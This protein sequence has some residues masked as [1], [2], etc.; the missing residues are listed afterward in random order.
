MIFRGKFDR[1]KKTEKLEYRFEVTKDINRISLNLNRGP[2]EHIIISLE[3]SEGRTRILT[4]FKTNKKKYYLTNHWESTSNCC[5]PGELP[6]GEW[7]LKV[8]KNYSVDDEFELEIK[9]ENGNLIRK[10]NM[11][12]IGLKDNYFDTK[13]WY[14][15]ELHNHTNISDGA[16]T[17]RDLKKEL[18]KREI[19]FICP[20]EHNSVLTK[21]P[22]IDIPI[23]PSTELTLDDLGHFNLFGLKRLIDY[24]DL[25]DEKEERESS[26]KKI[27][28]EVKNQG[29]YI[30][31]NHPFH[32]TPRMFLGLFY[33]IDL[34]DLDFIEVINSPTRENNNPYYDRK[35]LEALDMLWSDGHKIFAVGGSDNHGEVLGD[36]L[37]YI[38]LDK[39]ETKNILENMKK[40]R[41]YIS[42][43]GEI[44]LRMENSGN[45]VYPGDE[46]KGNIS[47]KII[48]SQ[49]L[50]WKVIKNSKVINM[51][52]GQEIDIFN[53]L[54]DGEYL[55]IEGISVK[56]E[57]MVVINPIY[58][59]LKKPVLEKWFEI[60]DRVWKE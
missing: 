12:K 20:T 3:D 42:R 24:Y 48:A 32:N 35:A 34:K 5:I 51:I 60:K 56:D 46:V 14:A 21:Y 16:I 30:S 36:P 43:I 40:G 57:P 58:N 41:S 50:L 17:L 28:Q 13:E 45:I 49:I 22:D 53:E 27:F 9:I 2:F 11:K 44:K 23:I 59:N 54:K 4:S 29:G 52:V 47:I 25:I 37:N 38:R 10:E 39:Y 19:D 15:G 7:R 6:E 31:L 8:L 26:L 55:R 18:I 33:N 1:N